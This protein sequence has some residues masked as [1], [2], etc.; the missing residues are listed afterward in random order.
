MT[1]C[2][3]AAQT[4]WKGVQNALLW[5]VLEEGVNYI[6]TV[7]QKRLEIFTMMDRKCK[8]CSIHEGY[9]TTHTLKITYLEG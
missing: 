5:Q 8:F 6:Y 9:V 1:V 7:L 3:S 2:L 4:T